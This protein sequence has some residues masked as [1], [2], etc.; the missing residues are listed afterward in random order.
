MFTIFILELEGNKY[1]VGK[2]DKTVDEQFAEHLSGTGAEW[3]KL[4]CPVGI[5]DTIYDCDVF[6]EDKY[7][8]KYM[9]IYGIDNVRGGT[10]STVTLSNEIIKSLNKEILTAQNKCYRCNKEGHIANKCTEKLMETI[11]DVIVNIIENSIEL[12]T[13]QEILDKI[14]K[15]DKYKSIAEIQLK[16]K[17]KENSRFFYKQEYEEIKTYCDTLCS[18][19]LIRLILY[20]NQTYYYKI[21]KSLAR[22]NEMVCVM[23]DEIGHTIHSCEKVIDE[24]ITHENIRDLIFINEFLE[25]I[26]ELYQ[27]EDSMLINKILILQNYYNKIIHKQINHN[28][29]PIPDSDLHKEKIKL[30]YKELINALKNKASLSGIDYILKNLTQSYRVINKHIMKDNNK[31]LLSIV[32]VSDIHL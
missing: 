7:V 32:N 22:N 28:N 26:D 10:Y 2:T 13:S 23:C 21:N 12:L 3:T 9:S 11:E 8:K 18:E 15:N 5:V 14:N 4:H 19:G 31:L 30:F 29:K 20:T 16:Q 27:K 17:N 25:D 1:Y 6:D 24:I